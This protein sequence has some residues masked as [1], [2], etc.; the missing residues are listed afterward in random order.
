MD[1]S[2]TIRSEIRISD[3]KRGMTVE[4]NGMLTTVSEK[5]IKYNSLF[6]RYSFRGD[7]SKEFITRIQF[8][9]PTQYGFRLE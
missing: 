9:V 7:M 4:E 1:K 3:L 6:G 2:N 5:Q 8:K